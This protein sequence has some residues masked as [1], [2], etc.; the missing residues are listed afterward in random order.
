MSQRLS[1]PVVAQHPSS[2]IVNIQQKEGSRE[3][4]NVASQSEKTGQEC[5]S[6][7]DHMSQDVRKACVRKGLAMS[8]SG[9]FGRINELCAG[10]QSAGQRSEF[11]TKPVACWRQQNSLL[12]SVAP[13]IVCLATR[14]SLQDSSVSRGTRNIRGE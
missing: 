11:A 3:G 9:P 2:V 6:V 8:R 5:Q 10:A 14:A 1:S 13:T 7:K 4:S 12:S